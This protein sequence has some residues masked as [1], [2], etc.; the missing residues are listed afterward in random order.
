MTT[1]EIA[2]SFDAAGAMMGICVVM[3]DAKIL[4]ERSGDIPV[5]NCMWRI[6]GDSGSRR[7][8]FSFR[9][10]SS[11]DYEHDLKTYLSM[12]TA[13]SL[14][15]TAGNY[16]FCEVVD[17]RAGVLFIKIY[18]NMVARVPKSQLSHNVWMG[19]KDKIVVRYYDYGEHSL[20][21]NVV[22]KLRYQYTPV[23]FLIPKALYDTVMQ[24]FL[25]LNVT[26]FTIQAVY[27]YV[28]SINSR[29][30]INGVDVIPGERI[31][32]AV[33][34]K[35]CGALYVHAYKKRWMGTKMIGEI[36]AD[37]TEQRSKG[38]RGCFWCSLKE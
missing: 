13:A 28:R 22:E 17:S 23:N 8:R 4:T 30:I 11:L 6:T 35:L 34:E 25:S 10:D 14:R 5:Q 33:F 3:F 19:N 7:I 9:G 16:Y 2:D 37:E 31:D 20:A 32:A 1:Q 36:V 26:K 15:S 29:I 38:E 18:R 21:A 24:H 27:D 12:C